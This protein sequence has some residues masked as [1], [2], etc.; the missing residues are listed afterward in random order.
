MSR[1]LVLAATAAVLLFA[2]CSSGQAPAEQAVGADPQE[3]A[4]PEQASNLPTTPLKLGLMLDYSGPLAEWAPE[5]QKGFDLAIKHI[6]EA[7]GVW[8]MPVE[9]AI[10]D[11]RTDPTFAVEEARRL[12]EIERVH[13]IVGPM[14]SAMSLAITESVTAAAQVLVISPTANSSQLTVAED[15][16]FLFRVALA[17]RVEG[18]YLAQLTRDLGFNNVALIYRD[19]AVGQGMAEAFRENWHGSIETIGINPEATTYISELQQSTRSGAEALVLVI[20]PPE[21][22]VILREALEQGYYDQFVFTAAARSLSLPEAIGAEA[23]DGMH[24][25]Y[26]ASAP[27]ND[28]SRAWLNAFTAEHGEPPGRPYIKEAYDAT[29][30]IAIAAQAAGSSDGVAIR[31]QLRRI[32]SGPGQIVIAQPASLAAGLA[33]AAAGADVDYEGAAGTIDWDRNGDITSGYIGVWKFT[34]DGS[35]TDVDVFEFV[36]E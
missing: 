35:I 7:G 30:A 25:T 23:L 22:I 16:D 12:V 27:E 14:S 11:D 28:S 19:D 17:D 4:E 24:G 8:G 29:I 3:Q 9:S 32:G 6:N 26:V 13:G 1:S 31:D 5:M 18:V 34:A 2:A 10:G 15:D 20:F 21:G 36:A 33:A